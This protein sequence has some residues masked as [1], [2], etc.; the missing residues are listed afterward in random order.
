VKSTIESIVER[1]ES[2]I[3]LQDYASF[4]VALDNLP[5]FQ[6]FDIATKELTKNCL[7][8][9]VLTGVAAAGAFWSLYENG[10]DEGIKQLGIFEEAQT[11]S[12]D[13]YR[14]VV[15]GTEAVSNLDGLTELRSFAMLV[16][17]H[18]YENGN[19]FLGSL[20]ELWETGYWAE[21]YQDA[22]A[23]DPTFFERTKKWCWAVIRGEL[24]SRDDFEYLIDPEESFYADTASYSFYNFNVISQEQ[25]DAPCNSC[26]ESFIVCKSAPCKRNYY[27]AFTGINCSV[28]VLGYQNW[29]V[30]SEEFETIL[31]SVSELGD[32]YDSL[33]DW[34]IPKIEGIFNLYR[35]DQDGQ[36]RFLLGNSNLEDWEA[37][38]MQTNTNEIESFSDFESHFSEATHPQLVEGEYLVVS[39]RNAEETGAETSFLWGLYRGEARSSIEQV[40]R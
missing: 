40:L 32:D 27:S 33:M 8:V 34:R 28:N 13:G 5:E 22:L 17:V 35:N 2:L 23:K 30:E 21:D 15:D 4:M 31:I 24:S 20:M 1:L 11:G 12:G 39:W 19:E 38:S 26:G 7:R 6:E 10:L 29:E 9:M 18:L 14:V 37:D 25:F 36:V 3:E 16:N